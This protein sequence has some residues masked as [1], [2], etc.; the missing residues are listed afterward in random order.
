MI[1]GSSAIALHE[2]AAPELV[3]LMV[4]AGGS[5]PPVKY[6]KCSCS[7]ESVIVGEGGAGAPAPTAKSSTKTTPTQKGPIGPLQPAGARVTVKLA[8][9]SVD[10]KKWLESLVIGSTYTMPAVGSV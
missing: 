3:T 8:P 1:Q 10:L 6:E 2:K 7:A 9:P 5:A 4:C